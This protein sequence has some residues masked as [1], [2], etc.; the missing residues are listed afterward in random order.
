ML[1]NIHKKLITL[2]AASSALFSLNVY[3]MPLNGFF[4]QGFTVINYTQN[5]IRVVDP[6]NSEIDYMI[7]P[8]NLH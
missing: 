1:K 3:S 4:R 2:V 8:L 6:S 5:D 7:E